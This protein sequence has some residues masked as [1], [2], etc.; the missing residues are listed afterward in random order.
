MFNAK[1]DLCSA[2][3]PRL[4]GLKLKDGEYHP[5]EPH[6]AAAKRMIRSE[7]LGLDVHA[8]NGLLRFRRVASGKDVRHRSGIEAARSLPKPKPGRR[9]RSARP[10]NP[11][12]GGIGTHRPES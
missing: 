11:C 7:V 6:L 10:L 2:G 4:Q 9:P 8:E 1:G 3:T 12:A 5:L